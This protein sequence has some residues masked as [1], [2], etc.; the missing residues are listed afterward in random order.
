[1]VE[2][3]WADLQSWQIQVSSRQMECKSHFQM[4]KPTSIICFPGLG[5]ALLFPGSR[6]CDNCKESS[7]KPN[8]EHPRA[9]WELSRRSYTFTHSSKCKGNWEPTKSN[10]LHRMKRRFTTHI[11]AGFSHHLISVT[12]KAFFPW[13]NLAASPT[14][15]YWN[16]ANQ[17]AWKW[18]LAGSFVSLW[19]WGW[20]KE[21]DS[22]LFHL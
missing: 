6:L 2:F 12:Y 4:P 11:T 5:A 14:P 9:L 19:L 17:P 20:L 15:G 16:I 18:A 1:M 21:G 22:E 13:D 3:L 8:K 7:R 10:L